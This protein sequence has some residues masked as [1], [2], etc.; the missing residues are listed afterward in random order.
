MSE[1][2][3]G[4][5]PISSE[6]IDRSEEIDPR[7]SGAYPPL[8]PHALEEIKAH[9]RDR[10]GYLRLSPHISSGGDPVTLCLSTPHTLSLEGE[11]V[12]IERTH[13]G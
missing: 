8:S 13:L 4:S 6:E 3:S 2:V 12:E 10:F 9:V 5:V 11:E 1:T 7:S